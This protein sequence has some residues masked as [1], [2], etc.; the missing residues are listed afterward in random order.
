VGAVKRRF[1]PYLAGREL[2]AGVP[3]ADF[4]AAELVDDT[5]VGER[6]IYL[7]AGFDF[8]PHPYLRLEDVATAEA[9]TFVVRGC[10]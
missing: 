3:E 6:G 2:P 7:R 10:G 1:K 5:K 9:G 4:E 8:L